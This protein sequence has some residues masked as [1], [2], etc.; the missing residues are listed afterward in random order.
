MILE[1]GYDHR[2]LSIAKGYDPDYLL[3][4]VAKGAEHYYLKAIEVAG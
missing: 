1:S 3:N 2:V 4:E